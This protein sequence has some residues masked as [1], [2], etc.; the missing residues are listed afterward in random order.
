[1]LFSRNSH[2]K[3]TVNS[4][5]FSDKRVNKKYNKQKKDDEENN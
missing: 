1:M 5:S 4:L 3:A 2:N